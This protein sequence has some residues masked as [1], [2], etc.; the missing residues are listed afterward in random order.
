MSALLKAEAEA[1]FPLLTTRGRDDKAWAKRFLWRHERGDKALMAVQI[2]F[3][4]EAMGVT[5]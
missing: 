3:A 4:R 1:K 5:A 2:L